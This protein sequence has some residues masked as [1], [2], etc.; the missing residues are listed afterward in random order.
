MAMSGTGEVPI[1]DD[2]PSG[3]STQK[4]QSL[5]WSLWVWVI[6]AFAVVFG[7]LYR[8]AWDRDDTKLFLTGLTV[9]V[10]VYVGFA[11]WVAG[12]RNPT[13]SRNPAYVRVG[14][15]VLV[16]VFVAVILPIATDPDRLAL[17]WFAGGLIVG[18][19]LDLL[20]RD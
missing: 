1:H 2:V 13:G 6:I 15:V 16:S 8:T 5:P 7:G 18:V 14:C 11:L 9:L 3:G 12:R 10:S 19:F 17:L 4:Q 20:P